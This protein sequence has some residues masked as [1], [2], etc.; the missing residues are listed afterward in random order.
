MYIIRNIKVEYFPADTFWNV[1]SSK[2]NIYSFLFIAFA[3][4]V[5]NNCYCFTYKVPGVFVVCNVFFVCG[6]VQGLSTQ[7]TF[8]NLV[9]LLLLL[10]KMFRLFLSQFTQTHYFDDIILNKS[11]SCLYTFSES[12]LLNNYP[13]P[14]NWTGNTVYTLLR[15]MICC[16]DKDCIRLCMKNQI[17]VLLSTLIREI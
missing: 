6:N 14:F 3:D 8:K 9:P 2:C 11:I 1:S 10:A 7:I 4:T 13:F 15:N 16:F 12:W 5:S 17:K